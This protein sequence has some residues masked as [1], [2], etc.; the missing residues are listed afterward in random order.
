MRLHTLLV[1]VSLS[2]L[3]ALAQVE[4]PATS[5]TITDLPRL[6]ELLY[7]QQQPQEQS[8]AAL[9]LVQSESAKAVEFVREGLRRQDRPDVFQAL[10]AAIR[11]H[12]DPRHVDTLLAALGSERSVQRQAA[13]E[14][15]ARLCDAPLVQRLIKAI[16]NPQTPLLVRQS[17]I[18]VLGQ[19]L[20]KSC[21]STL[22]AL[23]AHESPLI[24]QSAAD[25]LEMLSGQRHGLD[26]ARWQAWWQAHKDL[27]EK[28]WLR[29]RTAYFADQARRLQAEVQQAETHI[30]QLHD[31]LYSKVPAADRPS[32]LRSLAQSNYPAVRRQAITWI[33]E[34]LP[35]AET[36]QQK[37][38]TDGLLLLSDDGVEA[39]QRQAVLALEKVS[40]ERAFVRLL[41]LLQSSPEKGRAAAARSLG[42]YRSANSANQATLNQQAMSALQ[43]A[44]NDSSLLVVAEAAESL[45]D[46]GMPESAPLL[47]GLLRHSSERVRQAAARALELVAEPSILNELSAAL[48]DPVASVRFNLVGAMGRVGSLPQLNDSQKRGLLRRL[49][50]VLVRDGDPGVRSRA[51]TIIGDFGTATEIPILWQR[52]NATED[53]RVQLKA[54]TAMIDILSRSADLALVLQWDQTLAEQNQQ[55][56]RLEMLLEIRQ[57]WSRLNPRPDVD[58]VSGALVQVYLVQRRWNLALPLARDLSK[59]APTDLELQKRLRWLLVAGN[60]AVDEQKPQ[61][62]FQLLKDVQDLLPRARDLAADFDSLRQRALQTTEK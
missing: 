36:A 15:L 32:H 20:Q 30:L 26:T 25:A 11:L 31:L 10:A 17:A 9:L 44:L 4:Q 22:I 45:G 3:P 29:G 49:E 16:E 51:A 12:R 50:A 60:Q 8:Q 41:E 53:S 2:H 58:G 39:V 28:G 13:I 40:D 52:V 35:S 46:L 6:R 43:K 55:D 54:W 38:L 59:R 23:L 34:L 27:D 61:E 7:N 14:T 19:S 24:R 56:R 62:A 33:V 5:G 57:R 48:E 42:R 1:L 18:A 37:L 21:V 47:A